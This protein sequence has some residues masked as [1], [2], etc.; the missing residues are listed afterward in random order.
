M[1]MSTVW[2]SNDVDDSPDKDIGEGEGGGTTTVTNNS[3]FVY[4]LVGVEANN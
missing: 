2:N 4:M 3:L 1:K